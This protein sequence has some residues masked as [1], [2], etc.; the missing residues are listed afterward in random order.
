ME[1]QYADLL[2]DREI[3]ALKGKYK[4]DDDEL[5]D[6]LKFAYDNEGISLETAYKAVAYEKQMLLSKEA[7]RQG[8]IASK[9]VKQKANVGP[10]SHSPVA[11]NAASR[12]LSP[13]EHEAQMGAKL[14]QFGFKD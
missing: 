3:E 2:L 1:A 8:A 14:E 11:P 10:S 13:K 5:K 12:K 4:M 7:G 6:V 9:A